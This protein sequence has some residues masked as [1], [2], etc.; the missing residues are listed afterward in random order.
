MAKGL[1]ASTKKA[2]RAKLR[3]KVFGPVE[4][5]RMQRLSSRL[6]DIASRAQSKATQDVGVDESDRSKPGQQEDK[7]ELKDQAKKSS[8]DME[9]EDSTVAASTQY[10]SS[11][12][13][14]KRRF[15]A[16]SSVAFPVYSKGKKVGIRKKSRK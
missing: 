6:M 5:A 10:P 2:N 13:I 7:T 15:K 12:R 11:S 4:D 8:E 1:R 14:K 16:K 9:M 3:S